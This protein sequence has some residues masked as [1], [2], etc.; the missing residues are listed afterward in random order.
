MRLIMRVP[1]SDSGKTGA[2]EPASDRGAGLEGARGSALPQLDRH[3]VEIAER[4]HDK[5]AIQVRIGDRA[6]AVR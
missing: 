6:Q 1:E 4:E 3:V 2:A 5:A